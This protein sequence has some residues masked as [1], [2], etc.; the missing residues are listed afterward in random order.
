M[1]RF[2]PA[3]AA[4]YGAKVTEIPVSHHPRQYGEA[5][6]GL[7]RTFKVILD[8]LTVKFLMDYS[9]KPMHFLARLVWFP[10]YYQLFLVA[11]RFISN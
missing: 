1:H 7:G 3:Y 10:F 9:T 8:L 6:Y 2:I 4:W 11:G 5:K